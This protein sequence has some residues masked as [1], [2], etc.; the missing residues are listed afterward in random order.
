MQIDICVLTAGARWDLL[1]QCLDSIQQE[2]KD[3]KLDAKVYLFDNGSKERNNTVLTHPVLTSVKRVNQ[4]KGFPEGANSA[5]KMGTNELVLFV[6]DDIS[7]LPGTIQ[8][9]V[10]TMGDKSIGLVGLKL[11]FPF[12]SA[13]KS[14]P[15]G[16]VQHVGH[17]VDLHGN[18]NHIFIGWSANNLKV[19]ESREVFSVTGATFMVRRK[20]FRQAGGF[21]T[22]FGAGTWEDIDLALK[23]RRLGYKIYLD[24]DAVA[25]HWV[26]ATAEA[27]KQPFPLNQNR[28]IFLQRWMS[29]GLFGWDWSRW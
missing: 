3:F 20:L 25:Q 23:I 24:A 18:V 1:E 15:A 26:G 29:T 17:S 13:D 16:K 6:S 9:L 2:I 19:C 14:R 11:L 22:V 7:F 27:L 8:S 5:I 12:T 10:N 28:Q 21:D 4:N